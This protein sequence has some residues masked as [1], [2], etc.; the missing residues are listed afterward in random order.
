MERGEE[1]WGE[2]GSR[3]TG[4]GQCPTVVASWF[5][6]TV[7]MYCLWNLIIIISLL[8]NIAECNYIHD[9]RR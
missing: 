1:R 3:G 2:E 5:Y 4:V 9:G 6:F 8:T 7:F